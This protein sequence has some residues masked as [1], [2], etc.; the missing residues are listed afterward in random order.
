[1]L[2]IKW[3]QRLI[4]LFDEID[5]RDTKEVLTLK[6]LQASFAIIPN[7]S[8]NSSV[9]DCKGF[10]FRFVSNVEIKSY[11]VDHNPFLTEI[12]QRPDRVNI[13]QIPLTSYASA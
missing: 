12:I 4:D 13:R 8:P 2:L 9:S 6:H 1:M 11:F 5:L 3:K 7:T 10:Y